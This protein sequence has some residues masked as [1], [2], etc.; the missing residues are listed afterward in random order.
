M[1]F[2]T[3]SLWL[4]ALGGGV[5][6]LLGAL[7]TAGYAL[8]QRWPV[9]VPPWSTAGGIG[10]TLVI[11]CIAGLYPAMRASRVPPAAAVAT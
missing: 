11:G 4:S 5:G 6:V 9:V 2:L 1:Q 7:I 3:E 10:A 8:H